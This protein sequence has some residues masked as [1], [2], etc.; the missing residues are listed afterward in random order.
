MWQW[1]QTCGQI[2]AVLFTAV[3]I[4]LCGTKSVVQTLLKISLA[5]VLMAYNLIYHQ[6]PCALQETKPTFLRC[7]LQ[8]D[9]TI[10]H[11]TVVHTKLALAAERQNACKCGCVGSCYS[12]PAFLK[13]KPVMLYLD[14]SVVPSLVLLPFKSPTFWLLLGDCFVTYTLGVGITVQCH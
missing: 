7:L 3:F 6:N 5:L 11:F 14:F 2:L 13:G 10:Q 9:L 8:D 1:N 4:G 12:R